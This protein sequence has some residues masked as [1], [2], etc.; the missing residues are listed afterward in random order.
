MCY[1]AEVSLGTFATVTARSM[2]LWSRDRRGVALLLFIIGFMQL[3]EYILWINPT[4]NDTNKAVTALIPIYLY[5]QPAA[6]AAAVWSTNA[7]TGT[8][9]P[10]II[11]ISLI[12]LIPYVNM[13]RKSN[14]KPCI[15]KGECG[16]LD[17]NI[18][19]NILNKKLELYEYVIYAAYYGVMAYVIGT[20]KNTTL[21]A[22]MLVLYVVS[23][24]VTNTMYND[25]W[26]SV[27]CH[28]VNAAAVAAIFI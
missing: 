8:F 1:S 6:I 27:W 18:L 12:G 16:H 28:S 2:Y 15:N 19:D 14:R 26:G 23:W 24:L 22:I 17:W 11:L 7:G 9:Y 4:C 13:D 10:W 25:V 20:L 21:S 5:L 3:L